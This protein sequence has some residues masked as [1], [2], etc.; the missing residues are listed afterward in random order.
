MKDFLSSLEERVLLYDGAKGVLLQAYGLKGEEAAES[1]NLLKPEVVKSIYRQYK[2]AGSDVIQT[3]TFPGNGITLQSHGLAE[4]VYDINYAGVSLAKEVAGNDVY[5]AASAGPT[6]L[7]FAPAGE[8]TFDRAY[9]IFQEQLQAVAAAGAD[10]VNFETFTDLNELRA[11][12]L[13]A[14]EKTKLPVIASVTFDRNSSTMAGNPAEVCAIVCQALGVAAVG[15]NCSGGPESLLAPVKKM[16][17]VAAL[18]LVVKPNAGL[19]EAVQGQTVYRETPEHFAAY[20]GEF[21]ASG[22]RLIG[23]C[24]GTTPAHIRALKKELE[25]M[26]APPLKTEKRP[27]IASAYRYFDFFQKQNPVVQ[28]LALKDFLIKTNRLHDF[29][30]TA[31]ESAAEGVDYLFLDFTAC[32]D[33]DAREFAGTFGFAVK[34]PVVVQSDRPRILTEF[35]RYYPG[36]AGVVLNDAAAVVAEQLVHYGAYILKE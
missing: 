36:R 29:I 32:Q 11:A 19:P 18:P 21:V 12:I 20:A 30:E 5:V 10:L 4:K 23:G 26:Q 2:E 33:F 7:L 34:A 13:A 6:G 16:S 1:W 25:K 35:L 22:A 9:D 24:C 3:N 28:K 31:Q 8:L 17:A 27:L 14:K 15:A